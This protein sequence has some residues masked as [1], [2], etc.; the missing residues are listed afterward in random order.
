MYVVISYPDYNSLFLQW[1]QSDYYSNRVIDRKCAIINSFSSS[2]EGEDQ[3]ERMVH[4][5]FAINSQVYVTVGGRK[6]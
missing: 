1:D 6:I 2:S 5:D 3:K 4:N